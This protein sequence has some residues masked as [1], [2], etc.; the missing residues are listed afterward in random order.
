MTSLTKIVKNI[1]NYRQT[2]KQKLYKEFLSEI[3][4]IFTLLLRYNK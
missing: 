4:M 3:E 2:V 1:E